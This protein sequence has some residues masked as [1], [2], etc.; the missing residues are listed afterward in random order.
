MNSLTIAVIAILAAAAMAI[1]AE[2]CT[3]SGCT[4]CTNAMAGY[5]I[6]GDCYSRS[7]Y[8]AKVVCSGD[9]YTSTAYANSDCSGSSVG[10]SSQKTGC[11]GIG[12]VYSKVSCGASSSAV[13]V[14]V[15][16]IVAALLF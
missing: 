16:A 9:N 13:V 1:S 10:E 6:T 14:A 11:H 8:S 3:D 4:N 5:T 7:G 15:A 2:T 12:S